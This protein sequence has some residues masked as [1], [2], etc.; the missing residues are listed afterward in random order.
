MTSKYD[1]DV[2]ER[3]GDLHKRLNQSIPT[4]ER[5]ISQSCQHHPAP[6]TLYKR[7]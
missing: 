1:E 5:I 4:D 3:G 2:A 6:I 7:V